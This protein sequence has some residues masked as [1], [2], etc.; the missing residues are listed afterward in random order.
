MKKNILR[1]IISSV[2][3]VIGISFEFTLEKT[4][5][6]MRW[7][8]LS[9]YLLSYLIISYDVIYK[10]VKNTIHGHLF[11]EQFLMT[12]ATIGAFAIKQYSEAVVVM[13]LYQIGEVFQSFAVNK[14][15][16]DIISLMDI[17]PDHANLITANDVIS[18]EPES[19]KVGDEILIKQGERVPLDGEI[20]KGSSSLNM[21]SLTGESLPREVKVGDEIFSGSIN[22][23]G[24]LT[25]KVS[26]VYGE[27]TVSKILDLVENATDKKAKA[28]NLI[29]KFA[30]IYTPL[31]VLAAFLLFLLPPLIF[32]D[33]SWLDWLNRALSFLVVSCPCAFVI[34]V[35]LTYFGGLGA[36]SKHGILV[37]GSNY[38]E[39]LAK[40][41]TVIFDKTG[42]LTAGKFS[43][44]DLLNI[45]I[46]KEELVKY[47]AY[48]EYS[49][50]HPLSLALKE[51]Y[52]KEIN[53]VLISDT[54]EYSGYGVESIV[55]GKTI[56]VGNIKLME[57]YHITYTN[58]KE[59]GTSIYVAINN[60]FAGYFTLNDTLKEDS[61][62][63]CDM[64]KKNGIKEIVMLTGDDAKNTKYIT[65]KLNIDKN[66]SSLLPADKVNK[67]EEII[68]NKT[69]KG[70]VAFVGDGINDAPSI[71]RADV[72]IA[73]GGLGSDA[74]IEA[75]D[76]TIMTDEPSK[77]NTAISIARKTRIIVIENIVFALIVKIVVLILISFNVANMWEAIFADVGVTVIAVCNALRAL[78]YKEK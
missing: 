43:V 77:I 9:I 58:A 61:K 24:L 76:I 75:S 23:E 70:L 69:N 31:V 37:K 64:L 60:I 46:S 35:P 33:N 13:I 71:S 36:A 57:K 55:E 40:I 8:D 32:Q 42:T 72:G 47:T 1:I 68:S 14:S 10:A 22:L 5:D 11:D 53:S 18:C 29:T 62:E 59:S 41:E 56:L 74:A 49:S 27:S 21:A 7:V 65:E 30:R 38:L 28:E 20:I 66:Y 63:A 44:I 2:L 25:V 45:N 19:I 16:K 78:N 17:R 15:R 12:I 3:F 34:S 48:A 73:M 50:T 6:F 52:G 54:K 4:Y 67:I 26:K 51:Y 39:A